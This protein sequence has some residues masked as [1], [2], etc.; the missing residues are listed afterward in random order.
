M[1][2]YVPGPVP[3]DPL[4]LSQYLQAELQRVS[5]F[6][7]GAVSRSYGGLV[8]SPGDVVTLLTP[9]PALFDPWDLVTPAISLPAGVEADAAAGTLTFLT[10][11]VYAGYFF[12]TSSL[13]P[14][15]AQYEF[16][17]ARNGVAQDANTVIDPSNQTDRMTAIIT[18]LVT[19]AKGDVVTV[20]ASSS[21][22]DDWTSSESQFFI[23]RVSD[24]FD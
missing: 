2:N 7:A 9:V 1:P 10:A 20:L 18:G 11:G 6:L 17:F 14:V 23:Y 4:A 22:S 8:Q 16:R 19:V 5:D 12:T 21:T 3:L 24:S 15:N 13:L